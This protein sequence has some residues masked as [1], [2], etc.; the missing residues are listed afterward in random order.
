MKD[1]IADRGVNLR[2]DI[3]GMDIV[4]TLTKRANTTSA[5]RNSLYINSRDRG[6]FEQCQ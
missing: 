1:T 6:N 4:L 3:S 2:Q 5:S